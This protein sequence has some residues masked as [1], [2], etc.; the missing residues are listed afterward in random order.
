MKSIAPKRA[1]PV[2]PGK[3]RDTRRF[4]V[5][6][7]V[8]PI[9]ARHTSVPRMDWIANKPTEFTLSLVLRMINECRDPA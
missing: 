3:Y 6:L 2:A 1:L 5:L 9:S 4:T 8:V 7:L